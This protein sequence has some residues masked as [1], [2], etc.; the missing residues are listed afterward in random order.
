MDEISIVG[1]TWQSRSYRFMALRR[2]G[3]WFFCRKLSRPQFAKFMGALPPCI[4]AMEDCGTA[5]YWGREFARLGHDIRLVP[6][7]YV[8]PFV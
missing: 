8:K 2:T 3:A 4:V 1:M 7:V 6:P 5:H